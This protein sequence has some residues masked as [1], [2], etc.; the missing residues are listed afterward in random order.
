LGGPFGTY[1]ARRDE[2]VSYDERRE[3]IKA[4]WDKNLTG[5]EI[6]IHLGMTRNAVMG[7]VHRL[8]GKG[9][10]LHKTAEKQQVAYYRVMNERKVKDPPPA[11][12][13]RKFIKTQKA[14]VYV[15]DTPLDPLQITNFMTLKPNSCKY[16]ISGNRASEYI[17][18]DEVATQKS[19][20]DRHYSIC[21]A[22]R[23]VRPKQNFN[24][25]SAKGYVFL[26][27]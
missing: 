3:T 5:K 10:L 24:Q 15:V 20:C 6:S 12:I 1:A 13:V 22:K 26:N 9:E 7:V 4:M 11:P 14:P 2:M 19:Y 17:F 21:Y 16:S 23:E 25:K 18:C 8:I 27:Y